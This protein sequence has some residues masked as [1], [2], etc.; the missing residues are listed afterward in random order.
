MSAVNEWYR[1][2]NLNQSEETSIE[3]GRS[4]TPDA[5][6]SLSSARGTNPRPRQMLGDFLCS[7]QAQARHLPPCGF[8]CRN[9]L[10]DGYKVLWLAPHASPAGTGTSRTIP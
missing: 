4:R 5:G 3:A 6:R 8:L 10:S 9:P 1:D 2:Y 7:R